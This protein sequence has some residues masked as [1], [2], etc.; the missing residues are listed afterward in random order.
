MKIKNSPRNKNAPKSTPC[1]YNI[2][3]DEKL[4]KILCGIKCPPE[5]NLSEEIWLAIVKR[6]KRIA[7]IEL[8]AFSFLGFISLAALVPTSKM[9]VNHIRI[10]LSA[11]LIFVFFLSIKKAAK[12]ITVRGIKYR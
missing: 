2:N 7:K 10:I 6:E 4:A 5:E 8:C 11:T 9:I 12:H 3:M 1:T